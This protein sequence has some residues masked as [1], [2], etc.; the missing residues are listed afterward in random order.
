MFFGG[1]NIS[2]SMRDRKLC[3]FIM[4]LLVKIVGVVNYAFK[5]RGCVKETR[6]LLNLHTIIFYYW[7]QIGISNLGY[8]CTVF[9]VVC[10]YMSE[11][12]GAALHQKRVDCYWWYSTTRPPVWI[13][14][15]RPLPLLLPLPLLPLPLPLS[16]FLLG[17]QVGLPSCCR[18]VIDTT[19]P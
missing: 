15:S 4:Y 17:L 18:A 10:L 12:T 3:V 13:P 6:K 8:N 16:L 14:L 7:N 19:Y 9:Y 11:C 5:F 1:P 2:G